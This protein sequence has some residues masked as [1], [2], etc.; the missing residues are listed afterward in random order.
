M[1]H[2]PHINSFEY[3]KTLV[4]LHGLPQGREGEGGGMGHTRRKK[5]KQHTFRQESPKKTRY[6]QTDNSSTSGLRREESWCKLQH[7][8][9]LQVLVKS[10]WI[11]KSHHLKLIKWTLML[12][13][14]RFSLVAAAS[15]PIAKATSMTNWDI[16]PLDRIPRSGSQKIVLR[17][18]KQK[19]LA[20]ILTISILYMEEPSAWAY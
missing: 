9:T 8:K 15:T 13:H 10:W 12:Q 14:A 3:L 7:C 1:P 17:K 20:F 11:T 19:P 16:S 4:P 18:R 2:Q 5:N 6:W